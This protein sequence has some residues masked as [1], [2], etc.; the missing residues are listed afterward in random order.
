[1]FKAVSCGQPPQ[2]SIRLTQT[3][4]TL[5]HDSARW[6]LFC[7]ELRQADIGRNSVAP[8][9]LDMARGSCVSCQKPLNATPIMQAVLSYF[10]TE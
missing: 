8:S 4:P 6:C 9:A 2:S 10:R 5:R 1:M 3:M 7:N